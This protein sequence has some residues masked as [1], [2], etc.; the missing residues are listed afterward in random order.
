MEMYEDLV[1]LGFVLLVNL[2]GL[3]GDG[4]IRRGAHRVGEDAKQLGGDY[5]MVKT[6]S[7]YL[8]QGVLAVASFLA[9]FAA[10]GLG[11]FFVYFAVKD[12]SG[13]WGSILLGVVAAALLE[14][15]AFLSIILAHHT[16]E[17]SNTRVSYVVF[18][19][20]H[21]WK[22]TWAQLINRGTLLLILLTITVTVAKYA[23]P[24]A[25]AEASTEAAKT[26]VEIPPAS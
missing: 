24:L 9:T 11:W 17:L 15:W 8:A 6:M 2:A 25:S 10:L 7:E 18:G 14:L 13:P 4:Y 21:A 19:R 20:P 26:A 22:S 12:D 3:F 23:A 1:P 16:H 5:V